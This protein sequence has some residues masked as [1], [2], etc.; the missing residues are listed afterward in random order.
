MACSEELPCV[1]K[2]TSH[3]KTKPTTTKTT[4]T[5]QTNNDTQTKINDV[6]I[7]ILQQQKNPQQ[8]INN[9][10]YE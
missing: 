10:N 3:N 6:K 4:T 8:P 5:A 2:P 7:L 9:D 1:S